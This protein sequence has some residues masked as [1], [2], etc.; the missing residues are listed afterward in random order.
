MFAF[1]RR[2]SVCM[3]CITIPLLFSPF[4]SQAQTSYGPVVESKGKATADAM[5]DYV[6][7][8]LR[9]AQSGATT[10]EAAKKASVLEAKVRAAL[11]EKEIN[12]TSLTTHGPVVSSILRPSVYYEVTLQIPLSVV[13]LADGDPSKFGALCDSIALLAKELG[14]GFFGPKFGVT[15]PADYERNAVARAVETAYIH[16][17]AVASAMKTEI[18]SVE[19]V[20][21]EKVEWNTEQADPPAPGIARVVCTANVRVLYTCTP[22]G[23]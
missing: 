3:A 22:T 21:V 23:R 15:K 12:F 19:Q 9:L 5:P 6:E 4:T 7:F 8:R 18:S 16:G 1:I 2:T 14:C 13:R 11:K 20:I 10:E 17:E